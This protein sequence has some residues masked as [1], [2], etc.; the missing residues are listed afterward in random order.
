M[1]KGVP[2][3]R[4]HR[5]ENRDLISFPGDECVDVIT[6]EVVKLP[7]CSLIHGEN[8]AGSSQK[9]TRVGKVHQC[10]DL[11]SSNLS[12]PQMGSSLTDSQTFSLIVHPFILPSF[13]H[14]S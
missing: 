14:P 11:V 9:S 2:Q 3:L 4:R 10:F 8:L 5:R 7:F 12:V 1:R 13:S 6:S